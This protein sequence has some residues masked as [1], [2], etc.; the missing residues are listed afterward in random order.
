MKTQY[1]I[2]KLL[3]YCADITKILQYCY[4]N[5]IIRSM[6]KGQCKKVNAK[7]QCK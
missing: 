1:Y 4:K 7:G 6:Q 3:R 5:I 2:Y